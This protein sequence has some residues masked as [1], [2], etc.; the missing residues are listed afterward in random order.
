MWELWAHKQDETVVFEAREEGC[1]EFYEVRPVGADG[2]WR[3]VKETF[4]NIYE[5]KD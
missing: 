3:V 1:G 5:R 4:L 2:S